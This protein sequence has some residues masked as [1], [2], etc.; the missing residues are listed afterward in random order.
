MGFLRHGTR[1]RIL[2]DDLMK[3]DLL[4]VPHGT[5]PQI[6]SPTIPLAVLPV[7]APARIGARAASKATDS[8]RVMVQRE[9]IADLVQ[10]QRAELDPL[11]S[12][13]EGLIRVM[14]DWR[15][16]SPPEAQPAT[17]QA[18]G[19]QRDWERAAP[20]EAPFACMTPRT[21]A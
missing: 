10:S 15:G 9:P 4:R 5:S 6:S 21:V 7:S 12:V 13:H 8:A 11:G 19:I 16:Q 1:P 18:P 14:W 3:R 20:A 2:D 17:P